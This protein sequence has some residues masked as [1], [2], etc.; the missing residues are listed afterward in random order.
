MAATEAK[1]G[2]PK[3]DEKAKNKP[4]KSGWRTFEVDLWI[5]DLNTT[6][7]GFFKRSRNRAK[8]RQFTSDMDIFAEIKEGGE[9]VGLLGYR[10]DLWETKD[11]MDKRLVIKLFTP[12]MNWK[13]TMDLMVGRSLQLTHGAKGVPVT[14]YSVNLT[15]HDQI[16]QLERSAMKWPGVPE[17][18]SFM[19]MKN[20]KDNRPS[21]YR[22]RRNWISVGDDYILYNEH[23]EQ[24]G[25][26]NGRV[27]NLGGKWKVQ[28]RD[29]E[30]DN[31][32]DMV[33]QLFCAMLKFND[34]CQLHIQD[35]M[36]DLHKGKLI[37]KLETQETDMYL[38]PRRVR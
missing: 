7:V 4:K 3:A 37:P 35:L 26:L 11:G 5:T 24:I 28:I 10:A 25:K 38:N 18:F 29:D 34:E 6:E 2:K 15:D 22:L 17:N 1:T 32:L 33:I 23:D 14:A 19:V 13:A 36:G 30:A 16:I 27:L 9:R 20:L 12:T 8:S 21:F 31:R